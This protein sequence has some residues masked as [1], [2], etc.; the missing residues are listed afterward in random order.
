M[1][2]RSSNKGTKLTE[3][4]INTKV[5]ADNTNGAKLT[6]ELNKATTLDENDERVITSKAVYTKYKELDE[7]ITDTKIKYRA[8]SSNEIKEVKL[9]KGLDFL[10]DD[11]SNISVTVED[12]GKIK[13]SLANNLKEITSILGGS[14]EKVC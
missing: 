9:S 8:N 3:K 10:K 13:H 2:V 14:D 12:S 7:K 11:N 4:D 6:L 5:E 1:I